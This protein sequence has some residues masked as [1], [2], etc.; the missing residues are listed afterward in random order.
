MQVFG[1]PGQLALW[2]VGKA[3]KHL[4]D[5]SIADPSGDVDFR[6]VNSRPG[7]HRG[8][9]PGTVISGNGHG[10][11]GQL[12]LLAGWQSIRGRSSRESIA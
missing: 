4:R 8:Y 10:L 11:L 1:L 7:L 9:V 5:R 12:A 6:R 2:Q 3:D